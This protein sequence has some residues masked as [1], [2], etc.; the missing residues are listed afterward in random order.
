[1]NSWK[2]KVLIGIFL[3]MAACAQSSA[4]EAAPPSPATGG[5][6]ASGAPVSAVPEEFRGEWF[7]PEAC[8]SCDVTDCGILVTA[9]TVQ[10]RSYADNQ[11][12]VS[13]WNVSSEMLGSIENGVLK[14]KNQYSTL[15][16]ELL[17]QKLRVDD[18]TYVK[19]R[20][21]CDSV[22]TKKEACERTL[23]RCKDPCKN[24]DQ[25]CND[26]CATA[27]AACIAAAG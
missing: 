15:E 21:S 22:W 24:D 8:R 13:S 9:G 14:L 5:A 25:A 2:P 17:G 10:D 23:R 18:T 26:R 19:E 4:P 16:V 11:T 27:H 1:V 12:S 6:S 20:P 3:S 7:H